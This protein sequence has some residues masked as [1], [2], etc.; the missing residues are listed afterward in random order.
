MFSNTAEYALRA[1]IWLAEHRNGQKYGHKQ[2]SEGTQ[3]PES[4]LPKILKELVDAGIIL[5]KRG[6]G[7]GFELAREPNEVTLLEVINAVD[8]IQRITSCPLKL[9]AHCHQ[10][11]PVHSKL[12]ATI[13][14]MELTLGTSTIQ[15]VLYKPNYP[16]PL[17]DQ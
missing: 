11:C 1:I 7:G 17:V 2:I 12:D 15:E 4:Y 14:A 16:K 10:L 13:E 8:P 5:S 9:K 3:V 6:V